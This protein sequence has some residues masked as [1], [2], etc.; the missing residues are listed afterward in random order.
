[1]VVFRADTEE[2][3]LEAFAG[4]KASPEMNEASMSARAVT[5]CKL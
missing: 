5:E 3:D 1:M 4:S 2:T